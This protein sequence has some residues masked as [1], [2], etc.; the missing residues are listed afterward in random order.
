MNAIAQTFAIAFG[1]VVAAAA[2]GIGLADHAAPPAG[3]VAH[4][5]RV[6]VVVHRAQPLQ[7]VEKLPRVVIEHHRS[8]APL[9]VAEANT[10][11]TL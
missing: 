4:L 5:A 1:S 3:P 7:V 9:T 11:R 8:G 2:I 6:A 10:P